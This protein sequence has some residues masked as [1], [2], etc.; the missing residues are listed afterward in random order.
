MSGKYGLDDAN[1]DEVQVYRRALSAGEIAA[2]QSDVQI[3]LKIRSYRE[4]LAKI[5]VDNYFYKQADLDAIIQ[6]LDTLEEEMDGKTIAEK[7]ALLNAFDSRYNTFMEGPRPLF[8]FAAGS[9]PH[10]RETGAN[11]DRFNQVP[12]GCQNGPADAESG[13]GIRGYD[14]KRQPG[15]VRRLLERAEEKHA[16]GDLGALR[17]RQPR[18]ARAS[19]EHGQ[20]GAAVGQR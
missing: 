16:R 17:D 10:L 4:N 7:Q 5:T 13:A 11:L 9:D 20:H 6:A 8:S 12:R 1:V 15:G 14:G 19:V 3:R 2:L 18:R